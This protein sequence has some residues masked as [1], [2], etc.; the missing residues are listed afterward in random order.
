MPLRKIS[1]GNDLLSAREY[2]PY[3]SSPVSPTRRPQDGVF[4]EPLLNQFLSE[5]LTQ[6]SI[7]SV[8]ITNLPAKITKNVARKTGT[9]ERAEC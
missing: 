3:S 4:L 6:N 1:V 8:Y 5:L 2:A 9:K 7:P